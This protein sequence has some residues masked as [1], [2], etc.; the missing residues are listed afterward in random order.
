MS[1]RMNTNGALKNPLRFLL[2]MMLCLSLTGCGKANKALFHICGQDLS[3]EETMVFGYIYG[4]EYNLNESVSFDELY[5]GTMTYGAYCKQQIQEEIVNTMLLYN[6]SKQ[7]NLSLSSE[8]KDMVASNVSRLIGYYGEDF[9]EA[10]NIKENDVETVYKMKALA[11]K[12]VDACVTDDGTTPG[13]ERYVKVCQVTFLTAKLDGNGN[14]DINENGEVEML[15]AGAISKKRDEANDF[16]SRVKEGEDINTLLKEYDSSVVGA[17]KYLKY[18]DLSPEY[19]KAVDGLAVG[20][21]S[22]PFSFD[23]GYYVIQLLERDG[24]DFSKAIADH[25]TATLKDEKKNEELTRLRDKHIGNS[26]NYMEK[27]WEQIK[28][29][30]FVK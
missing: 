9:F 24:G 23:Y 22:A 14:Y 13:A 2:L 5:E 19:R 8:E 6:E 12:Y 4:M 10:A 1:E 21:T 30:A 16:S 18:D 7:E 25:D 11:Q 17:E 28:I 27:D 3:Y 15:D 26:T 29:E 20:E